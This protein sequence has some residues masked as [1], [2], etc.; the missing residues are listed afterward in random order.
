[1]R[2]L[3]RYGLSVGAAT[4]FTACAGNTGAKIPATVAN[5]LRTDSRSNE[6]TFH[7]TGAPQIFRVPAN[8][9]SITVVMRG[10]SSDPG[11]CEYRRGY[12]H[13]Y[14]GRGARVFAVIPVTPHQKLLIYV[15]GKGNGHVGGF[16]GGGNGGHVLSGPF[17]TGGAGASDV[18]VAPGRRVD[19][20]LVAGGA[21]GQGL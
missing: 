15:G 19:R 10:A 20:I 14:G 18:R 13:R 9:H 4:L 11:G 12:H 21:G 5:V 7:Y 8:V 2:N 16:D 3:A 17:P 1:M 6:R